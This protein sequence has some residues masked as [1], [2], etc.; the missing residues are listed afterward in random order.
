MVQSTGT[1]VKSATTK[2]ADF[3]LLDTRV[4][5]AKIT[6]PQ[7][8]AGTTISMHAVENKLAFL[9]YADGDKRAFAHEC[10]LLQDNREPADLGQAVLKFLNKRFHVS[11][12]TSESSKRMLVPNLETIRDL[13][14]DLMDVAVVLLLFIRRYSSDELFVQNVVRK[15]LTQQF[16]DAVVLSFLDATSEGLIPSNYSDSP[17][18]SLDASFSS[19]KRR[20]R[21]VRRIRAKHESSQVSLGSPVHS[22][23]QGQR[24][25]FNV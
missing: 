9:S 6:Q 4:A 10:D 1:V 24:V 14:Q 15:M 12:S 3:F 2:C 19:P 22:S 16:P 11:E 7:L 18:S 17:R 13:R 23:R 21:I 25:E 20:I 8:L 5:Q